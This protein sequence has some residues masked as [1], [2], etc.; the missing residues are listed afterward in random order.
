[1]HIRIFVA[2]AG[3]AMI[4][5]CGPAVDDPENPPL[6]G[7]WE[8]K[9]ELLSVLVDGGAVDSEQFPQIK[10]L[11]KLDKAPTTFCG[12]PKFRDQESWQNEMDRGKVKC[13]IAD[14][15]QNGS[16]L[17]ATGSCASV[18][19]G[20][21]SADVTFLGEGTQSAEQ[22]TL[23]GDIETTLTSNET[24]EGALLNVIFRRTM[25]RLGDC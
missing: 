8:D 11:G 7:K 22:A 15:T 20:G 21:L 1:M 24:G 12:E 3:F 9:S 5:A 18:S 25:T 14:V 10:K 4:A 6:L 17:R 2:L 16:R 23:R 19:R 13:T